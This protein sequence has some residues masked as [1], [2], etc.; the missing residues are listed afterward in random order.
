MKKIAIIGA[1][2]LQEPLIEKAK[3]MGLETHVFAWA[4]GDIGEKSADYFYPISIVE[5]DQIL[6]KCREIGI[7]G[8]CSI[9]SDLAAITVN[10]VADKMGLVGN[11][12]ECALIS[13]NKHLMREAFEKNGDPS[14]KS[15]LITSIE[16][17]DGI[18]LQ[19]PVI[20]KPTDRSGSRGITKLLDERGLAEAI[21][22]AKEQGFE[23]KAL[24]EEFATGQEYSV[25]CVSCH[26]EHHFLAMTKKYTTGAP[27]FIETGHLEPAPVSEEILRKVKETVFHALDSLKITNSASH[28]ELKIASDG[29]IRLI[30]IGGRMGGDCIGSDLVQLSTGVD[31]V[32]AVIQIALGEAP[33]LNPIHKGGVA[34]VHYIFGKSDY[35][36]LEKLK[37]EHPEFIVREEISGECHGEITDSGSRYGA[38]LMRADS[39]EE[40]EKYL[41]WQKEE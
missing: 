34:S 27:H 6:D 41:P 23:K 26:G 35:D 7:A 36:V 12:P 21:E 18:D 22:N 17:L 13:T 11:S 40:L 30:E 33:D 31:F 39:I 28:S 1:S 16:D 37:K 38:F 8:I 14:P 5:K 24:V 19:Y 25:E 29:T 4:A 10:Y 9:A 32:R 20:V 3:A 2:Y 15:I